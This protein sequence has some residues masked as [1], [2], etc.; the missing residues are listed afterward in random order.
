M[1]IQTA[2]ISSPQYQ[3]IY[4]HDSCDVN[5]IANLFVW[6]CRVLVVACKLLVAACR[7]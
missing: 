5:G 2:F 4:A 7:I 6:L 3:L 1:R